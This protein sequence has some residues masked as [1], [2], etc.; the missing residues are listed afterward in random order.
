MATK[1]SSYIRFGNVK[2]GTNPDKLLY[3]TS[4]QNGR[5]NNIYIR[6][7]SIYFFSF[8]TFDTRRVFETLGK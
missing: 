3:E 2:F 8:S 6:P 5:A 4:L 1:R 7:F